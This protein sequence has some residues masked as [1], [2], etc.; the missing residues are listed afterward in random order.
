MIR[1]VDANTFGDPRHAGHLAEAIEAAGIRNLKLNAN[2][3]VSADMKSGE[4][5]AKQ[6]VVDV[7]GVQGGNNLKARLSLPGVE[8]R[9]QTF[10]ISDLAL[11]AEMRQPDQAFKVKLEPVVKRWEDDVKAKGIDGAKLVRIA[12]KEIAKYSK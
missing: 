2:G 11:N 1:L 9:G 3:D 8:T 4:L 6:F 12:R 5:G 7:S 10:R